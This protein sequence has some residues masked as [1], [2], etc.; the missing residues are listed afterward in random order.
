MPRASSRLSLLPHLVLLLV[1]CLAAGSACAPEAPPELDVPVVVARVEGVEVTA[2]DLRSA[3]NPRGR[4]R[5]IDWDQAL[6]DWISAR[7]LLQQLETRGLEESDTYRKR[8][9]AIRTRAWRAEQELVR[10][11]LI[12]ALEEGLTFSDEDLRARYEEQKDRFLTTRLH[13]RQITVPDRETIH[14]IRKQLSAGEDFARLAAQANLDPALRRK[15]GDLG[16]VEQRRMPTHLIGPAHQLLREGEVSD[17]FQDREG[18]WNLVQLLGRERGVRREF[19]HVKGQ[20]ERELRIVR[21]REILADLVASQ[22]ASI[23][24]EVDRAVVDSLE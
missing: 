23:P 22:R 3:G 2:E 8:L 7:I 11:T 12:T 17:P 20:L 4:D 16:W 13:L 21:S 10:D 24:V 5:A 18:R 6:E 15:S 1:L 19:D 9:A 14:A